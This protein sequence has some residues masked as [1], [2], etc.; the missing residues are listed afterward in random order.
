MVSMSVAKERLHVQQDAMPDETL[1]VEA[2]VASPEPSYYQR[3]ILAILTSVQDVY[4]NILE[5]EERS[6]LAKL[7]IGGEEAGAAATALSTDAQRLLFRLFLR[8]ASWVREGRLEYRDIGSIRDAVGELGAEGLVDCTLR[9]AK[10]VVSVLQ[11]DELRE[12]ARDL[13]LKV[14]GKAV[15]ATEDPRTLN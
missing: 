13:G 4:G 1:V 8:R 15:F 10:D 6:L 14:A 5:G 7:H 9:D 12:L 11:L 2:E 3:S